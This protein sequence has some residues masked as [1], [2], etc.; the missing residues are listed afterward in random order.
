MSNLYN[1][2]EDLC[3]NRGISIAEMCRG[4]EVRQTNISDLKNGRQSGLSAKNLDKIA[5]F[6]GVSVSYL[7]GTE[8]EKAPADDGEDMRELL[9]E[10]KD[11]SDL[12]A[13]LDAARIKK[14]EQVNAMTEL[15]KQMKGE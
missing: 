11:R 4:A 1:I 2:I 12:R 5:S 8:K 9:E 14:P 15:L 10:L 6:F 13:L 7:L 3:K